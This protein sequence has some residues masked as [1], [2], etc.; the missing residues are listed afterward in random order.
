MA[1]GWEK[2][3]QI[4]RINNDLGYCPENC[5]FCTNQ[6]NNQNRSNN[7]MNEDKVRLM[8]AMRKC[9]DITL[10]EL[11]QMF[12]IDKSTASEICS[13]ILWGNVE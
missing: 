7:K 4:D 1:N 5:R 3:L 12:G 10:R 8:K 6:A 2:G 9:G 13:G 11:G